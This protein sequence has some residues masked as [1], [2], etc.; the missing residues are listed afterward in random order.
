MLKSVVF[1]CLLAIIGGYLVQYLADAGLFRTLE[2][3]GL[4]RCR[5]I[6]PSNGGNTSMI[7]QTFPMNIFHRGSSNGRFNH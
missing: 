4:D 6:V 2:P 1:F 5:L 3:V 7:D